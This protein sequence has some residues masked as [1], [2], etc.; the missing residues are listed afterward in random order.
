VKN[1]FNPS[2]GRRPERFIGR[3][4]ITRSIISSVDDIN[5]PWRTTLITGVRGS[6]KTALLS[7]IRL[8]L[9]DPDVIT[10]YIVPNEAL[11]DSILS[12]LYRQLPKSASNVLPEFKGISLNAGISVELERDIKS[13]DFTESFPYRIMEMMDVYM[14]ND[15]HIV[16]LVDETQKHTE[17]MR[18]FI[19][20]Y[21]D[22]VMREYSVSMVMA[23]LPSVVSNI[24]N[25]DILSF[26]RRA[27][28]VELENVELVTVEYEFKRV[29]MTSNTKLSIDIISKAA[30]ATYGYPYLFQLVGYYLWEEM[31][32]Y[33]GESILE[34]VLI[35]AKAEL[36]RNVHK[37]IFTDLSNCDKDF[38]FAMA[39]DDT[40]SVTGNIIKRLNKEKN[41]VSLYRERL[42][43]AGVIKSSGYGTVCFVYPYMKEFLMQK[44]QELGIDNI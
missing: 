28:Q 11:L 42:I 41:H 17:S 26:L 12:Q 18:I 40:A 35:K 2:F 21:Q 34:D 19:S 13:P 4:E 27:K 39:E 5:S 31:Q 6:G 9:D 38:I 30:G 16:F 14:K 10:L 20:T 8:K 3:E 37:L 23:G 33:S 1:P 44:K 24:L 25:D 43:S 36:F 32:N 7:D 29:F 15:K 22:L